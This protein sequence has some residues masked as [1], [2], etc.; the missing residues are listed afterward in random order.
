MD[1]KKSLV[2]L[3]KRIKV[4]FK[5]NKLLNRAITH[6]SYLNENKGENLKSNERLEFL[7][8]AVLELWATKEL[9]DR[10]PELPEGIMTNIRAAIV[11]TETLAQ[12]SKKFSFGDYL[13]LSRGEDESGGRENQSLLAN[14]FEAIVGAIFLDQGWDKTATFLKTSLLKKLVKIGGKGDAK[15][16]KTKLQEKTQAEFKLAP[17]YKI[18]KEE[19]PDH[20]KKFTISVCL[21]KKEIAIGKGLS[22]R[23]AEEKAAS[24]ALTMIKKKSIIPDIK[25]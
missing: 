25:S 15:D 1:Q 14:T 22:K 16:S 17:I 13:L 6:R 8:D 12:V 10:F 9:F 24:K 4:E 3:Q 11:R 20:N 21:K 2:K 5:N 7:G 18:L 23:E 19:G